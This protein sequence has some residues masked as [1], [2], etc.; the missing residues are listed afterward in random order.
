MSISNNTADEQ[1]N[2]CAAEGVEMTILAD[3]GT[4]GQAYGIVLNDGPLKGR[5]ARSVFVVKGGQIVYSE[6]LAELSDEPNYKKA[7]EATK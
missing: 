7:L 3:D 5:L 4:F 2:W 1:K 6:I